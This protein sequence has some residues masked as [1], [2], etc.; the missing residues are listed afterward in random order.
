MRLADD[1]TGSGNNT[2]IRVPQTVCQIVRIV[3]ASRNEDDR[4][5]VSRLQY[6]FLYL[7]VT[8]GIDRKIQINAIERISFQQ[9][10]ENLENV[11]R[12]IEF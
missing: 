10:I 5:P 7:V 11:A 8:S 1:A 2:D 3:V 9:T 4:S 12:C 6:G